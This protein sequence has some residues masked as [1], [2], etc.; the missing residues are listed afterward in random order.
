MR[1]TTKLVFEPGQLLVRTVNVV[2]RNVEL[3]A[4]LRTVDVAIRD[5]V[6]AAIFRPID[7][8]IL[9]IEA[10]RLFGTVDVAIGN[11]V[12]TRTHAPLLLRVLPLAYSNVRI[13]S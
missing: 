2:V 3:A 9:N 1:A 12:L 5:V 11:I 7:V 10:T 6:L 4:R 13:W 8:S